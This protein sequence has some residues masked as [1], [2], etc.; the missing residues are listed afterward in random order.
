M[1]AHRL[2]AMANDIANYFASEPDREAGIDGIANHLRKYWDPRMRTQ[3]L[4]YIE[5]D[6]EG[7][8]ALARAGA[9]RLAAG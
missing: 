6:G 7:L 2:V 3:L 5:S 1:D 4:A 8:H 9:K